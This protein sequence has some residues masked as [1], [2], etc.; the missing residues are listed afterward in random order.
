MEAQPGDHG[1]RSG[2]GDGREVREEDRGVVGPGCTEPLL[3]LWILFEVRS[4]KS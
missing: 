1:D 2:V 3:G 4:V